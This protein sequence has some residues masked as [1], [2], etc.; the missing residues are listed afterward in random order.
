MREA[1][2]DELSMVLNQKPFYFKVYF[3][4]PFR[5]NFKDNDMNFD[6]S[7]LG[8][9]NLYL[10]VQFLREQK[11]QND[12]LSISELFASKLFGPGR[13]YTGIRYIELSY[14]SQKLYLLFL[15]NMTPLKF[16]EV[17]LSKD[18]TLPN[19][20]TSRVLSSNNAM[21]KPFRINTDIRTQN[22]L[23]SAG[24]NIVYP[25]LIYKRRFT[26]HP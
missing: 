25:I 21:K 13:S 3:R 7:K 22:I 10:K 18:S 11:I 8:K 23:T 19:S 12:K 14:V 6:T 16:D 5:M 24:L 15:E 20:L 1:V 17:F 2:F 9:L 4:N 26:G